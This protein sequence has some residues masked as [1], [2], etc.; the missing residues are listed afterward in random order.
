[1]Q[2]GAVTVH[3]AVLADLDP[4]TLYRILRL[5]NEVFVVEQDCVYLDTDGRDTEPGARQ[6]W[7]AEGEQVVA[8]LRLLLDHDGCW[9][10]GRVATAVDA[11]GRGL[12]ALLMTR[13]LQL[14][15]DAVV[16][17]EAQSYLTRWYGQFG[18][19]VSGPDYVEDG[20]P[21][22]PMRRGDRN[23]AG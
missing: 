19:E 23:S 7:I 15:G 4:L 16:V 21:H 1:M 2:T 14:A 18:F 12:A 9:R 13:A 22:T 11:R 17:L 6:L 8:T 5:R 3:D 10:I 20:I